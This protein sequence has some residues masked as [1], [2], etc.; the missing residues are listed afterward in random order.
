MK[1]PSRCQQQLQVS[2]LAWFTL[3][4]TCCAPVSKIWLYISAHNM[5]QKS[6]P[7]APWSKG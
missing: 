4:R 2:V 5:K 1:D 6:L 7:N 3:C